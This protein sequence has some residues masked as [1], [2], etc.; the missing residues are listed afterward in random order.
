MTACKLI[1][2]LGL[3]ELFKNFYW[4]YAFYSYIKFYTAMNAQHIHMQDSF[5]LKILETV[6]K[7][8]SV[9]TTLN[10]Q[11]NEIIQLILGLHHKQK[12][13]EKKQRKVFKCFAYLWFVSNF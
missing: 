7:V 3:T 11:W 4:C 8:F 12:F 10:S 1:Y 2:I 9:Y 6:N 13:K 5:T